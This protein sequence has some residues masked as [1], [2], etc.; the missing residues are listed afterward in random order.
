MIPLRGWTV[1]FLVAILAGCQTLPPPVPEQ[2][3]SAQRLDVPFHPQD[4][5]QCGPA[6][7]A[8]ALGAAGHEV[9]PAS[10]VNEVWLPERKGS[11]MLELRAAARARER[12]V[13][14]VETPKALF[15]QLD[16]GHPVLVMQN[17]AF[18]FWPQWHFAVAIGYEEDGERIV[19][20][21][22]TN[23]A[24][25]THWN[26]F[27][28]TWARTD[29]QGMVVMRPGELPKNAEP[30][31]LVRALNDLKDSA[32]PEAARPYWQATVERWP[33][34]YLVQFGRGNLQWALG[35]KEQAIQSFR[36][37]VEIRPDAASAWNNLA[38][39]WRQVGCT[40]KARKAIQKALELAPERDIFH[41]TRDA[42]RAMPASECS[43]ALPERKTP[44]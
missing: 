34:H 21:T 23:R 40:Q 31:E 4:K 38:E 29:Y 15:A 7:L 30:R 14:P 35:K 10:L 24:D 36:K 12:L 28:R 8:M 6:A 3:P 37:A 43:A 26:R 1:A 20:H 9:A 27:V 41:E 16:A 17:L 5:Y 18:S 19:L 11:L 22:G 42:I 32:G 2:A 13:Y 33:D 25:G 39:A 44:R